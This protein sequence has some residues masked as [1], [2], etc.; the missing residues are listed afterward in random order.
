MGGQGWVGG[1]PKL[2]VGALVVWRH[3][4]FLEKISLKLLKT[5][6]FLVKI[7]IFWSRISKVGDLVDFSEQVFSNTE[8]HLYILTSAAWTLESD[9]DEGHGAL[10]RCTYISNVQKWTSSALCGWPPILPPVSWGWGI[11]KAKRAH[12]QTLNFPKKY[13]GFLP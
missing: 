6:F 10:I 1:P 3:S 11:I 13:Y 2:P 4:E 8:T 9:R 7:S 5:G 12:T